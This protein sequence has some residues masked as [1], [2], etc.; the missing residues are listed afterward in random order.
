MTRP[1]VED[2]LTLAFILGRKGGGLSF[3]GSVALTFVAC[4]GVAAVAATGVVSGEAAYWCFLLVAVVIAWWSSPMSAVVNG[5]VAFL[6]ANGFAFDT[7]GILSWHGEADLLR[8]MA[9]VALALTASFLGSG[10]RV[11]LKDR[12]ERRRVDA[13]MAS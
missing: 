6:F 1:T 2:D 10:R 5:C 7:D 11:R 13:W 9:V 8:L 4:L 3:T 12:A